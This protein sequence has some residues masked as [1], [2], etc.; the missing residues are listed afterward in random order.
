[1]SI[2]ANERKCKVCGET[3]ARILIG[4]YDDSNKKYV[5]LTGKVWNGSCCP[6]CHVK[7]VKAKM[8]ALREKKAQEKLLNLSN[9]E[10]SNEASKTDS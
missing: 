3:K 9:E 5:D 8:Q 2:E 10:I 7:T 1:M 6:A 4:R